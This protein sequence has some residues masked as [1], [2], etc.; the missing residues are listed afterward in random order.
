MT[1]E[2]KSDFIAT[3]QMGMACGLGHP[4][5]WLSNAM[6]QDWMPFAERQAYEDRIIS[7]FLAFWQ[8]CDSGPNDMVTVATVD[9]LFAEVH[10]WYHQ[11]REQKP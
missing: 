11:K 6:R 2:Q 9:D 1:P 5:E 3:A 4:W 10:R 8:G 7:A